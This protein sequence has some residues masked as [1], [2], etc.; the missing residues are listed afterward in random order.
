MSRRKQLPI[1]VDVRAILESPVGKLGDGRRISA[2]EAGMSRAAEQGASGNMGAARRFMRELRRYGRLRLPEPEDD[3]QYVIRIPKEW[4][5]QEWTWMFDQHG[6]PPWPG[7][8]DG[9]I[10]K[11]RWEANYGSLPRPGRRAR[12]R[13]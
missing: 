10:P 5:H 1:S 8:H 7:D 3:H 13:R 4:D 6:P 2:Y 11:E 9:L 12:K